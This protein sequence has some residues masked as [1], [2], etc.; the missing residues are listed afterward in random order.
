MI[1]LRK[2]LENA[3]WPVVTEGRPGVAL[4]RAGREWERRD[5]HNGA[6]RAEPSSVPR[7]FSC[8]HSA[9]MEQTEGRPFPQP[10][11]PPP[12]PPFQSLPSE[13]SQPPSPSQISQYWLAFF[14]FFEH[15]SLLLSNHELP[16]ASE[17]FHQGGGP[18]NPLVNLHPQASRTYLSPG[19]HFR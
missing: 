5:G 7:R 17:L 15:N 13:P 8:F 1:S 9:W 3:S 19:F 4:G 6:P 18:D 2:P 16:N 10:L 14:F 12:P 11:T